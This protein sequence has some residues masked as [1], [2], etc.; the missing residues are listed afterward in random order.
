[1]SEAGARWGLDDRAGVGPE[2]PHGV[3]AAIPMGQHL[4]ANP[5][6]ARRNL[7]DI[8]G[9]TASIRHRGILQPLIVARAPAFRL[10]HPDTELTAGT[11]FVL[12][13]GHRRHAAARLVGLSRVPA[14]VR[15]DIVGRADIAVIALVENIHRAKLAPLEEAR[16]LA[17]LRDL[18]VTQREICER[19]GISQGQVS[20]RLRLLD[21]P[22]SLQDG[23]E[24]GDL[25]V[26]D[27]LAVLHNLADPAEQ[28]RCVAISRSQ[29]RSVRGA[30]RQMGS[31]DTAPI[32]PIPTRRE[33]MAGLVREGPAIAA[34][35]T[36]PDVAIGRGRG[37]RPPLGQVPDPDL[38]GSPDVVQWHASATELRT[39]A[40]KALVS[41]GVSGR[42][43]MELLVEFNLDPPVLRSAA[44]VRE[45]RL[46]A[47]RWMRARMAMN[48]DVGPVRPGGGLDDTLPPCD[49]LPP[50]ELAAAIVLAHREIDLHS[51]APVRRPWR[52]AA[53][54]HVRRLARWAGY[55]PSPYELA[56]LAEPEDLRA[57]C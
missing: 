54:R 16:M 25:T 34:S 57:P 46:V 49:G 30:I 44:A 50:V 6:F 35:R 18:G 19:S 36:A 37:E 53:R 11:R 42:F 1:M 51:A 14:I 38:L 2:H 26:V 10:A 47:E 7:G 17:V 52:R 32:R 56:K 45:A 3:F 43:A 8:H 40:C 27:A 33:R 15:D 29:G 55:E 41:R 12:L 31:R 21:L 4:V 20:K 13:A 9:L 22:A 24:D 23:V 48:P 39:D 28:Q 5:L